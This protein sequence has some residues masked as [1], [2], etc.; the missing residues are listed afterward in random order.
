MSI[1]EC[2]V[3]SD[4]EADETIVRFSPPDEMVTKF[5]PVL[6]EPVDASVTIQ[7]PSQP[8][9]SL[10]SRDNHRRDPNS[11]GPAVLESGTA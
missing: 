3:T 7:A 11:F 1:P 8:R 10:V 5:P 6:Q 4:D 9:S 2:P